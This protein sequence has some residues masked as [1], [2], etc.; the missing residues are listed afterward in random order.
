[1]DSVK[2]KLSLAH[3]VLNKMFLLVQ[4]VVN[5]CHDYK[6]EYLKLVCA[7]CSLIPWAL[8]SVLLC[9]S[10]QTLGFGPVK[11]ACFVRFLE[12]LINYIKHSGQF[13]VPI[14][15]GN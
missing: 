1:M 7:T 13:N 8:F 15:K 14:K 2:F 6:H 4:Y 3:I 10:S 11:L 9:S 12:V 5:H